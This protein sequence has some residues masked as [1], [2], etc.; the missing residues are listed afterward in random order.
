MGVASTLTN[1]DRARRV[2]PPAAR[3]SPVSAEMRARTRGSFATVPTR[4]SVRAASSGLPELER[5]R[6]EADAE[7]VLR[8][9]EEERLLERLVRARRNRSADLAA[10]PRAA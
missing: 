5:E 2:S 7:L 3:S 6:H 8:R 10:G 9:V 4:E 1:V